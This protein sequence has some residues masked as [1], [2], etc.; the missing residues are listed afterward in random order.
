[1]QT[2][3]RLRTTLGRCRPQTGE[4]RIA[5]F[6]VDAPAHLLDEVVCHELA[7]AAAY[8]LHGAGIPPRAPRRDLT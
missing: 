6:L 8:A 7:H 4:I 1:V 3:K 5:A 2:S